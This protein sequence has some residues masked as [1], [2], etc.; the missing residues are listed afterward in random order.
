MVSFKKS[1]C[2]IIK[3][4]NYF[5]INYTTHLISST[6]KSFRSSLPHPY[7]AP[8]AALIAV[9][10]LHVQHVGAFCF[11]VERI[12][13]SCHQP[14]LSVYAKLIVAVACMHS[15]T[16]THTEKETI[17]EKQ[18]KRETSIKIFL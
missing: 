2:S 13:A 11:S 18:K 6:S 17:R 10:G 12:E 3:P 7:G 5:K 1:L 9:V 15:R 4:I 14:G 16:R 8:H